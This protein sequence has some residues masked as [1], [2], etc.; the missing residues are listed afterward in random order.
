VTPIASVRAMMRSSESPRSDRRADLVGGFLDVDELL[1]GK[2]AAPLWE[3]L[4]FQ[5]D[6]R[7]ASAL[8]HLHGSADV[9]GIAVAGI[10]VGDHGQVD[11]AG[12]VAGV[13]RHLG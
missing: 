4:V 8:E 11:A 3:D 10:G 13:V 5:M 7:H 12:Y 9:D 2:R 6:G 1:A